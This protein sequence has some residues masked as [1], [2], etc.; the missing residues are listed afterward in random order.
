MVGVLVAETIHP[1]CMCEDAGGRKA[2]SA[3]VNDVEFF[4]SIKCNLVE[5]LNVGLGQFAGFFFV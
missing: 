5:K 4:P 2:W 3:V 1:A